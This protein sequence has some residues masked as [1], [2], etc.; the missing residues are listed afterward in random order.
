MK[1]GKYKYWQTY[2]LLIFVFFFTPL[3][4]QNKSSCKEIKNVKAKNLYEAAISRIDYDERSA[5]ELLLQAIEEEPEYID[6]VYVL[7]D[8]YYQKAI[9]VYNTRDYNQYRSLEIYYSRSEKYFTQIIKLCPAYNNWLAHYFLGEFYYDIK[10][11]QSSRDLLNIF[12][13]HHKKLNGYI[14]NAKRM[15]NNID[16]FY[17]I[18]DNPVEFN[19]KPLNGVC[20]KYDEFLPLISPDGDYALYTRR[21]PKQDKN[22]IVVKLVEEF[23][24]SE[25]ISSDHSIIDT[26]SRGQIMSYPFNDGRNQGGVS[27]SIDNNHLYITICEFTRVKNFP[28]KNCDIFY[29]SFTNDKWS[30]PINMGN[31]INMK[32]SWEGQPSIS[33]DNKTLY[34]ASNR[35]G[36]LGEIDI[37]KT[38]KN[39]FGLWSKPINLG[40]AINTKKDD[41]SPFLHS[42]SQTLY[43]SSNGR[44]GMG[45]F[46]IFYSKLKEDGSWTEPRNIGYPI[47][48]HEDDI[49]FIVSTDGTKAYFSSNKLSGIG[50]HDIYVLNLPED[51]RPEKVL[52]IKG[53]LIDD[54]GNVLVDARVEVKNAQTLK[55]SRG[56]VDSLS[57]KYAVAVPVEEDE[58]YI[59]TVKKEEYTFNSQLINT[60]DTVYE[61]PVEVDFEVKPIEVGANVK[62]NNIYFA[63]NSAVLDE[64]SK[65]VLDNFIE[66]LDENPTIKI[67]IDGH[68][69]SIADYTFNQKLSEER[70]KTVYDYLLNKGLKPIRLSYKGFGETKP[71]DANRTETGRARNRRTEFVIL[72]K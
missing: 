42:D 43:F 67:R 7:A 56:L 68:T 60:N 62:L 47:N 59:M 2:L 16:L 57:G 44:F 19:P 45:G 5:A 13:E 36:G 26:F 63:F 65:I 51:A 10:N 66:F 3:Y 69:D 21:Y 50:G 22:S 1:I 18:V 54:L 58:V 46:D 49:G 48:T 12:L 28:Y 72:E 40:K 41:K 23:I 55:V 8:Y 33:A 32:D 25:R 37:Y 53:R 35:E 29:S 11:F 15:V 71:I 70:A 31:L 61:K 14:E 20:S 39:D 34:F 4:S 27:V 52:F 24:V 64:E 30:T 6:A 17:S 9:R 38:I